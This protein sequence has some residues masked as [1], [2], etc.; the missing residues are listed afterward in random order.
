MIVSHEYEFIFVKTR[1]TAGT[2]I[3]VHLARHLGDDAVVT[4]VTP[5][6]EGHV[7]RH[8]DERFNPL[9][10][11]LHQRRVGPAW[12]DLRRHRT[13]YNHIP[14]ARIRERVGT[15]VW[16]RYFKF[17]FERDPW[18]KVVSWY[19]FRR[20]R[21]PG[22]TFDEFVR[23][24]ALPSDFDL[25]SLDGRV[26]MDFVGQFSR[27]TTDLATALDHVG[28][29]HPIELTREKGTTRPADAATD[30]HFTPALDARV[31]EVFAREIAEFG[32]D[33]RSRTPAPEA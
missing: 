15:K 25:Y 33:D 24:Q 26:A 31:A 3:E 28:W 14:A 12:R 2:S 10:Q 30:A 27:L 17:C 8:H 18:E 11:M 16:D 21:H 1:K 4:P 6:V 9:P 7:A 19:Y 22:M 32:Y 23:T 5:P 20:D 29:P 13:F